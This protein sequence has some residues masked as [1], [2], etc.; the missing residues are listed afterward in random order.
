MSTT[1]EDLACSTLDNFHSETQSE[2][3][4]TTYGMSLKFIDEKRRGMSKHVTALEKRLAPL[5]R[6]K[7]DLK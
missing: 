4:E 3:L 1:V 7:D 2:G 6:Q 5:N